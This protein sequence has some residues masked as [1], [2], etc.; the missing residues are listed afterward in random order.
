VNI[1]FVAYYLCLSY[2]A[3]IGNIFYWSTY[4]YSQGDGPEFQNV[5]G[6]FSDRALRE[7]VTITKQGRDHLGAFIRRG[8]HAPETTRSQGMPHR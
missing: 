4:G 5:V 2:N 3:Y 6:L 1:I 7:P 8:I